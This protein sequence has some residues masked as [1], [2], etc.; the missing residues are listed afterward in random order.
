MDEFLHCGHLSLESRLAEIGDL[1]PRPWTSILVTLAD[2]NEPF[3]GQ[4]LKVT[5]EVAIRER[6]HGLQI[7]E[8]S[9]ATLG[10]HRENPQPCAL[11]DDLGQGHRRMRDG[12][13]SRWIRHADPL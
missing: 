7:G 4:D 10:Q 1:G 8:I 6:K 13:R 3:L 12:R 11:M 9:S 5:A 2:F